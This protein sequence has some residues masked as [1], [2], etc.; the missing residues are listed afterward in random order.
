MVGACV[1]EKQPVICHKDGTL[2]KGVVFEVL[3]EGLQ[4]IAVVSTATTV[5]QVRGGSLEP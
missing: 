4:F 2:R 3:K 1:Q 5:G